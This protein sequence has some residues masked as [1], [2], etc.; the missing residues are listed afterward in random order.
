MLKRPEDIL[1]HCRDFQY[2]PKHPVW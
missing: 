2:F 1:A